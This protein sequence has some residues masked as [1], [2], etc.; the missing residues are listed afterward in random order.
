MGGERNGRVREFREL[1]VMGGGRNGRVKME[2]G[3]IRQ[4]WR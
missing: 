3:M 2:G 4:G 1:V